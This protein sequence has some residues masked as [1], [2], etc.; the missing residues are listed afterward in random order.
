MCVLIDWQIQ[1]LLT[2]KRVT[3]ALDLAHSARK[4]SLS[5]QEFTKVY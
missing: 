3:E 1:S 5:K 2:D 4:L